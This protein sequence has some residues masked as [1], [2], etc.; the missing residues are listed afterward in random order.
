MVIYKLLNR[1]E[2]KGKEPEVGIF[3]I[4]FNNKD[5]NKSLD[6]MEKTIPNGK[7]EVQYSEG[8]SKN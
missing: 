3:V 6:S 2:E 7:M 5:K 1:Q 4:C 8:R